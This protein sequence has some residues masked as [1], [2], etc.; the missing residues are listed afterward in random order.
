MTRGLEHLLYEEGLRELGLSS[1]EKS[2][3]WGDVTV[4]FQCIKAFQ[5]LV[6]KMERDTLP[7]PVVTRKG[8][9]FLN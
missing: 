9:M 6:R 4:A 5:Y 7:R 8:T 3:L 2:R 1:L